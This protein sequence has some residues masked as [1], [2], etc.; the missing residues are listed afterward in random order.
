MSVQKMLLIASIVVFILA[1]LPVSIAGIAQ[2]SLIAVGLACLA[3][4]QVS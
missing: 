1:A 4:S 3:G 2:L